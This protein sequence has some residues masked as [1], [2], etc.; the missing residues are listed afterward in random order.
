MEEIRRGTI[1][2][3][4]SLISSL[5]ENFRP[6]A[7]ARNGMYSEFPH[8]FSNENIRNTYFIYKDG[9]PV[10][11]ASVFPMFISNRSSIIKAA[12]VGSV[13]T[14]KDYGNRGYATSI[15]KKI[16]DDLTTRHFSLMFVSGELE[17]YKKQSCVKTGYISDFT[18]E[19]NKNYSETD[20]KIRDAEYRLNN[21]MNYFNLYKKER[22]RHIR[23]PELMKSLL[24][25]LWFKRSGW[26]MELFD[27]NNG[28]FDAY[29]VILKRNN[30][31]Q[32]N[33]MEYSGNRKSLIR[34]FHKAMDYFHVNK[35]KWHVYNDDTDFFQLS[36]KYHI[37]KKITYLEGTVRVLNE[38]SLFNNLSPWF[39]ENLGCLPSIK[40]TEND[41]FILKINKKT[42]EI[43]GYGELTN[44]LFG[45]AGYSLNIPLPF[46]DDLSYI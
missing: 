20:V 30:M 29:A 35:I 13:S 25:S 23:T 6:G 5:N 1:S 41:I 17:L 7:G 40:K 3:R 37:D 22:L 36:T 12:A 21:Y 10:S 4:D 8:L 32:L 15:I 38:R 33:V 24:N 34:I 14:M 46:P 43:K 27:N 45:G 28:K 31:E 42:L 26:N 16:I 44:F 2:Y 9:K 11:Q 39:L 19:Y 18:I